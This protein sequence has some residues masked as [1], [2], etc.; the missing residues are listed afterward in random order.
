MTE[1]QTQ[2]ALKRGMRLDESVPGSGLGLSIVKD[3]VGEYGGELQ[4]GR[5]A[6]GGLLASVVLPAR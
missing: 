6:Q 2:L 3:I 1:E 5:S 4:F